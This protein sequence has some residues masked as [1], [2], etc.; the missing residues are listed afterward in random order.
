MTSLVLAARDLGVR[1][2]R[3]EVLRGLDV[4]FRPGRLTIV[5]GPN[6]AGKTTLLRTLAGLVSPSSGNVTHGDAPVQAMARSDRARAIAYLP[7]N[8]EVSW[9]LPV[10]ALVALGRLPY[11]EAPERLTPA[12]RAAIEQALAQV[13][14]LGFEDRPATE[15]SGGERGR[16][17]LA[18]ALA[19]KAPVLLADEPVAALDPRHQLLV[20]EVLRGLA[21][22]GGV[23]VAVMHDLSL[24]SRFADRILLMTGGRIVAEGAPADVLTAE[25]LEAVFGIEAAVSSEAGGLTITPRR[26]LPVG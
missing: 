14:L 18:R 15:L 23:V 3:R 8:G 11:G 24:A 10:R 22:A 2:G 26:A 25:R 13:G 19:T 1:L 7:Q 16:A 5:V 4:A 20:L 9:P 12:G 21:H 6:G 17:L